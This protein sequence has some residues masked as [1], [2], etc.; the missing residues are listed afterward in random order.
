MAVAV[1][2]PDSQLYDPVARSFD[3]GLLRLAM[4]RRRMRVDD[5]VRS[6]GLARSTV[7][8]ARSGQSISDSTAIAIF[9]ALER[10]AP[11]EVL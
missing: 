1:S 7:Q 8:N 11:M 5:L 4:I 6:T 3:P 2:M 10:I 9:R